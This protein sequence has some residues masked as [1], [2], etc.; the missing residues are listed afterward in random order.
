MDKGVDIEAEKSNTKNDTILVS[1]NI[2]KKGNIVKSKIHKKG[3]IVKSKIHKKGKLQSFNVFIEKL[4]REITYQMKLKSLGSLNC[5]N[6]N[7][8]YIISAN[9]R[10][11]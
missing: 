3:N 8:T 6:K 5:S 7:F 4:F 10:Y 1:V 11:N 9:Y 2:D